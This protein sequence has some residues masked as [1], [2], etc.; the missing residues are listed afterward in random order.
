MENAKVM[1]SFR[2]ETAHL[3]VSGSAS[4]CNRA[5]VDHLRDWPV[6]PG[7]K[8]CRKCFP[9]GLPETKA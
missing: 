2:N 5:A 8:I 7:D 9:N 1:I 4:L 3:Y 6:Q